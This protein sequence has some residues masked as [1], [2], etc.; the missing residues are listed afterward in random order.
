M[1]NSVGPRKLFL[2]KWK[3][4]E[5]AKLGGTNINCQPVRSK[6]RSDSIWINSISSLPVQFSQGGK[7]LTFKSRA[8]RRPKTSMSSRKVQHLQDEKMGKKW[9]WKLQR[10]A[11]VPLNKKSVGNVPNLNRTKIQSTKYITMTRKIEPC[12]VCG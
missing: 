8:P 7:S 6:F 10:I 1:F 4:Q 2:D 11:V 12:D 3:T 5:K 9:F